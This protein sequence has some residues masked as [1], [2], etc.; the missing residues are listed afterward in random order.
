MKTKCS[1]R[2]HVSV[3]FISKHIRLSAKKQKREALVW[4]GIKYKTPLVL[5]VTQLAGGV[6][7][8]ILLSYVKQFFNS[9]TCIFLIIFFGREKKIKVVSASFFLLSGKSDKLCMIS[10]YCYKNHNLNKSVWQ[11]PKLVVRVCTNSLN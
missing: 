3:T 6:F 10:L 8:K 1:F 5:C 2:F 9:S 7:S 11:I 4:T